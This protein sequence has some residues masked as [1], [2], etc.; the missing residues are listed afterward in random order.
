MADFKHLPHVSTGRVF[1]QALSKLHLTL[2]L[3]FPSTSLV[4]MKFAGKHILKVYSWEFTDT[5][6]T[7][8]KFNSSVS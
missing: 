7:L 1:N 8:G 2:E 6:F 4:S 3:N 5:S